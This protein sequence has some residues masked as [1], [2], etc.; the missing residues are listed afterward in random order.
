MGRAR[1]TRPYPGWQRSLLA[2]TMFRISYEESGQRPH[3][4]ASAI[5]KVHS[6]QAQSERS[7]DV[8]N[9]LQIATNIPSHTSE[10][11]K[12]SRTVRGRSPPVQPVGERS[13]DDGPVSG[14]TATNGHHLLRRVSIER[15][16]VHPCL[17]ADCLETWLHKAGAS[18]LPGW[19][20][21]KEPDQSESGRRRLPKN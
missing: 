8:N 12:K 9:R 10:P 14:R 5:S 15:N 2:A 17:Q 18:W 7:S 13:L 19:R 20:N 1:H 4:R 21:G 11:N 6:G 3:A 16:S